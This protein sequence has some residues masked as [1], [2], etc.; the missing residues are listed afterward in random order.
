M[1]NYLNHI[2]CK[3]EKKI[4]SKQY[5]SLMNDLTNNKFTNSNKYLL[6]NTSECLYLF[7]FGD[8]VIMRTIFPKDLTIN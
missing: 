2:I 5:N 1:G 8:G 7:C 6:N 4:I 3:P